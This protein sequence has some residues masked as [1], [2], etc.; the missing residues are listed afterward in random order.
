MST[1]ARHGTADYASKT[2]AGCEAA[3]E[4]VFLLRAQDE[5]AAEAI[6]YWASITGGEIA[7]E[8]IQVAA[9]FD[10]WPTKQAASL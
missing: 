10:R 3:G 8:A 7:T 5:K 4:P 1:Y 2:A 6:R 9:A